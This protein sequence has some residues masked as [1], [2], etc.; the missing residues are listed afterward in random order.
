MNHPLE[1]F[2]FCPHCGGRSLDFSNPR[3][4][5]CPQCGLKYYANVAS[6]VACFI[7]DERGYLLSVVRG[8]EPMKNTLDLPGGFVDVE[9]SVEEAVIREVYEETHLRIQHP[10]YLFS[11][12]N[13]Y[14]YSGIVVNTSDLFFCGKSQKL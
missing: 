3:A 12:P 13:I 4:I 14:P 5:F 2:K 6:A 9:E 10:R 1:T 11:I 8:R 7:T